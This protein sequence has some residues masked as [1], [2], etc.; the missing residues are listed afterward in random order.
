VKIFLLFYCSADNSQHTDKLQSPL[1]TMHAQ[2]QLLFYAAT[3]A[4][5]KRH[6]SYCHL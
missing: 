4:R 2:Q 6:P 5:W 3:T 1:L